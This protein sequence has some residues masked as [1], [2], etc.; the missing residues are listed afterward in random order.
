LP[1]CRICGKAAASK[2]YCPHHAKAH[3]NLLQKYKK[4]KKALNLSWNDYLAAIIQN[5]F[6]GR[7]VK[8]VA[9]VLLSEKE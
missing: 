2:D 6:S 4:W 3:H 8:E 5:P 1:K 9:E 7:K